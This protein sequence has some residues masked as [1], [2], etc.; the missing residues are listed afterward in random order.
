MLRFFDI[1]IKS[2]RRIVVLRIANGIFEINRRKE[3]ARIP[4]CNS[5]AYSPFQPFVIVKEPETD[6][7]R[8]QCYEEPVRE[9]W[10]FSQILRSDLTRQN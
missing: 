1:A 9:S 6:H 5:I 4:G 2:H 7:G 3:P 8:I 10:M